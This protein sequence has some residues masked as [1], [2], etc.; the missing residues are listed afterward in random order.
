MSKENNNKPIEYDFYYADYQITLT[1]KTDEGSVFANL[2]DNER[3]VLQLILH[4]V[5]DV[6]MYTQAIHQ[7]DSHIKGTK[8]DEHRKNIG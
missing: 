8:D 7:L 2:S 6:F 4:M 3:Q 5:L 1:I